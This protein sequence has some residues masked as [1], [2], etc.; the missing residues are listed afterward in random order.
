M[1]LLNRHLIQALINKAFPGHSTWWHEE[2]IFTLLPVVDRERN[3]PSMYTSTQT[4]LSL[5]KM[6]QLIYK[7]AKFQQK[8]KCKL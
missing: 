7:I 8:I 4:I 5:V 3:T 6:E 2:E 1:L